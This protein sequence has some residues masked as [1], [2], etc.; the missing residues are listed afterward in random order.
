MGKSGYKR[1]KK[2][3]KAKVKLKGKKTLLPKGQNVTN[4]TFKVKKIIVKEQLKDHG[5]HELLSKKHLNIKELISRLSHHNM[6][7]RQEALSGLRELIITHGPQSIQS[8]FTSLLQA[9][10][11]LSLDLESDV[12]KDVIKLLSVIFERM[13]E[14]QL[15]PL[16]RTI[17]LH[18]TC[19]MTHIDPSVRADSLRLIDV[20][21]EAEPSLTAVY[22]AAL[23]PHFLNLISRRGDG[24]GWGR[25]LSLHLDGQITSE[26]WRGRVIGRL[27]RLFAAIL[28]HVRKVMAPTPPR[29]V[30]WDPNKRIYLNLYY[31]IFT[32]RNTAVDLT[33]LPIQEYANTLM[34]L[35]LDTFIEA[36]PKRDQE[37]SQTACVVGVE[38]AAL[39]QSIVQIILHLRSLVKHCF[40]NRSESQKGWFRQT[41]GEQ[42]VTRLVKARFPYSIS[43]ANSNKRKR[44]SKQ[45]LDALQ[46][47]WDQDP[48][49][50]LLNTQ[51]CLLT[52]LFSQ[53]SELWTKCVQYIKNTLRNARRLQTEESELLCECLEAVSDQPS[54]SAASSLLEAVCKSGLTS[55]QRVFDFLTR[56]ACMPTHHLHTDNNFT[57]WLDSLPALLCKP[58]VPLSTIRN[59]ASIA[60]HIHPAFC[61]S[62]DGWYEQIICKLPKMEVTGDENNE[63]R[64]MVVG[65]AYR[66]NDWDL[67]MMHNVREIIVQGTLGPD[68]T[69]YLKEILWLKSEDTYNVELKTMLQELLQLL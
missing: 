26:K 1:F 17:V 54:S 43:K 37:D 61:N 33:N 16:F 56:I 9:A 28:E 21:L 22:T 6:K 57:T 46:V 65:L 15:T 39:L 63:G 31:P 13:T 60:T 32:K 51:L 19:A 8:N 41:W 59:I 47:S 62:L 10:M 38:M 68:L 23:M 53:P 69:R 64:R 52:F 45:V 7:M 5:E 42:V 40:R 4:T 30:E 36:V 50:R 14:E 27:N 12:R 2:Q 49:C 20:M 35:L 67:E 44:E 66:V 24:D 18:L 55:D 48:S 34:P 58:V 29:A 11:P 3:E 25:A